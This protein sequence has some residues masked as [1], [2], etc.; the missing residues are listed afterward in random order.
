MFFKTLIFS[1]IALALSAEIFCAEIQ[2]NFFEFMLPNGMNVFIFEDFS[3]PLV[4]AEFSAKAGYEIRNETDAPFF[5]LCANLFA[6]GFS[7][8]ETSEFQFESECTANGAHFSIDC[9]GA[10]VK[11]VFEQLERRAFSPIFSDE[12]LQKK[13]KEIKMQELSPAENFINSQINS[14]VFEGYSRQG[15]GTPYPPFYEQKNF[16]ELRSI[17]SRI[18]QEY[19]APQNCAIFVSGAIKA[20]S[21]LHLAQETFGKHAASSQAGGGSFFIEEKSET[22]S[23]EDLNAVRGAKAGKKILLSDKEFSRDFV[24]VVAQISPIEKNKAR[25]AA[26]IFE[27]KNSE[28]KTAL[29]QSDALAIRGS[30]YVNAAAATKR[31]LSRIV[32]QSLFEKSGISAFGQAQLFEKILGEEICSF[33][34]AEF[35]AAQTKICQ[36]FYDSISNSKLFMKSFSRFWA[37]EFSKEKTNGGAYVEQFL[38]IPEKI[39]AE[40]FADLK[41]ALQKSEPWIFILLNEGAVSQFQKE[42]ENSGYETIAKKSIAAQNQGAKIMPNLPTEVSLQETIPVYNEKFVAQ[43]RAAKKSFFLSNNIRV[44]LK[45]NQ[46]SKKTAVALYVFGGEA[47][48]AESNYGMQS[49]LA[50]IL[51]RNISDSLAQKFSLGE[52]SHTAKVETVIS[53]TEFL[54]IVECE[55]NE[56][57]AAL[58]CIGEGLLF[59]NF[60]PA[61][62]DIALNARR[63]KQI[64]RCGSSA[65]QMYSAGVRN[66]YKSA[67]HRSLYSPR[68][69]ILENL[70]YSDALEA[71]QKILDAG[72]IEI[73]AAGNFEENSEK[74]FIDECENVFGAL[75]NANAKKKFSFEPN[76]VTK[77]SLAVKLE[78]TF[79]TDISADKAGPRPAV[80]VPTTEF[81]DPVQFWIR[82]PKIY[83]EDSPIFDALFL[84][85]EAQCKKIAAQNFAGIESRVENRSALVSFGTITLFNAKKISD[86][87]F[88]F[89]KAFEIMREKLFANQSGEEN[90]SEEEFFNEIRT[91]WIKTRYNESQGNSET[92]EILAREASVARLSGSKSDISFAREYEEVALCDEEK[93]R[94][95]WQKYFEAQVFKLYS[96]D[97]KK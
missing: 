45:E 84:E 44:T 57:N 96:I 9:T 74:K 58:Q 70:K 49:V 95:V 68:K 11:K 53:D 52:I 55:K 34:E 69:E 86:A 26:E 12:A 32:L 22:K 5:L 83:E 19:Y 18:F 51:E 65:W 40:N 10:E 87:D 1:V 15:G 64:L 80:L 90:F 73:F 13:F 88:V 33:S 93:F 75:K 62:V 2:K 82:S 27:A 61:Q 24:Q 35:D 54:L 30:D 92:I 60:L 72:R 97:S 20:K 36:D 78:H 47:F 79:L 37:D 63:T 16:S 66:F 8:Q 28:F 71:Y 7:S 50:D 17:V 77:S 25:L 29:I 59:A 85:L 76:K 31:N 14:H 46:S 21:V 23:G 3:T 48:D 56:L 39:A 94:E 4:H 67:L 43:S 6:E 38:S 81:F 91:R 89:K 41:S 42:F